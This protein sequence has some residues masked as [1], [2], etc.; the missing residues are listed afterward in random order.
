MRKIVFLLSFVLLAGLGSAYAQRTITG[1]VTAKADGSVLPGV[2]VQVKGAT[3]IGTMTGSD[4]KYSINVPEE[5][6]TLVFSFVGMKTVEQQ[7]TGTVV[8][9]ALETADIAVDEVVVTALGVTRE[10]KSLGYATQQI[11]GEQVS[12]VKTD[13]FVNTMSG[14]VAGVQI[15]QNGNFGGSTN[16]IIRGT[17]S[18][19]GNNQA[20]FVVDGVPMDN[21]NTNGSAQR[22]GGSGYDYG[23]PVS[24]L[25]ADDIE[26]INVLKGAAATA[27]YGARAANGVIIIT[28]KKGKK[29][30]GNP[31]GV[32]VNSS[33]GI[34]I[35]DKSTFPEYQT[36][37]GA[38]YGPYYNY[39]FLLVETGF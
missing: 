1:T 8:N 2:T 12:E 28:T 17:T 11:G 31:I 29:Q 33:Y 30:E 38:G 13:N 25:N 15:K 36:E 32:T 27:L 34:G 4:G 18:L 35:V 39:G 23:S 26:S 21:S 19:T 24:D 6:N 10:K 16:I 22:Q 9:V 5:Y 14:K 3:G 7:I 37:Y 20:L